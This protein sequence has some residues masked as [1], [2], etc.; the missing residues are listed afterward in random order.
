LT[1]RSK[2]PKLRQFSFHQLAWLRRIPSSFDRMVGKIEA[3][4]E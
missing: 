2:A 4:A 1:I 3:S